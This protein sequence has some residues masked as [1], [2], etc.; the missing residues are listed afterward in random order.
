MSTIVELSNLASS[1]DLVG[2]DKRNHVSIVGGGVKTTLLHAFGE[3]LQGKTV[4]T[5]TTK[6]GIDQH[7]NLPVYFNPE[8][9]TIQNI[10]PGKPI[11]VWQ[12]IQGEKAI[13]V[14]RTTCDRWF[15]L[16][17][18]LVVEADG[19]RRLPF[20]AP[21][22]FEPVVPNSSTLMI[23]TIGAD[24][25]GRT[26]NASCHRPQR[27]AEFAECELSEPLTPERAARVILH[28]EGQRRANPSQSKFCVAITKVHDRNIGN[29]EE[30]IG[31]LRLIDT[32][33]HVLAIAFSSTV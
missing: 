9:G 18:N 13:G 2:K 23:S 15:G 25:L 21:A 11:V 26:I 4:L 14:D 3:Q 24:A 17:D 28:P 5:S 1:L 6:M 8:D 16:L 30:L 29:V 10:S 31:E 20:K 33:V 22:D 7:R 19:S 12:E 32:N 27:V